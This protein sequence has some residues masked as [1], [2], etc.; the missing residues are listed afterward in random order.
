MPLAPSSRVNESRTGKLL[1]LG[2][3]S[4]IGDFR[5]PSSLWDVSIY[6]GVHCMRAHVWT[7]EARD[8]CRSLFCEAVNCASSL[9]RSSGISMSA[10][11][12]MCD[13]VPPDW[14]SFC[15]SAKWIVSI[16]LHTCIR[17][18]PISHYLFPSGH[19]G[20]SING[21][22][23]IVRSPYGTVSLLGSTKRPCDCSFMGWSDSIM[24]VLRSLYVWRV[25]RGHPP[26]S[27]AIAP[28]A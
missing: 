26:P 23:K 4:Y 28:L 6:Q 21:L 7:W 13:A 19:T 1:V 16:W 25:T 8:D 10:A 2:F 18:N 17:W 5:D 12:R 22:P 20:T 14:M 24:R 3:H 15:S 11:V 9:P 27:R